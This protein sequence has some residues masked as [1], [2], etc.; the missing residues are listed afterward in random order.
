MEWYYVDGGQRAGPVAETEFDRLIGAGK[1]Q[2][3]TLV[4]R[5]GMAN[6][7]PLREIRPV[8]APATGTAY[9]PPVSSQTAP[10]VLPAP[11]ANEVVCA[12]CHG[13]F[14]RENTIQYGTSYVCAACKP[15]FIQ[16]LREGATTEV[17]MIYAGFWIR[18]GAK[19]IDGLVLLVLLIPFIIYV[20]VSFIKTGATASQPNFGQIAFQLL[21][22]FVFEALA[23][24]Y[25]TFFHG[26]YGATLGKLACGLKVVTPEGGKITYG[27]A[28]G[29]AMAEIISRIICSIGYII[30]AF[31]SQKRSL[32]DHIAST[33]VIR[34]R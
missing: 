14:P 30:A 2:P 21:G 8:A 25:R 31:D 24:A 13:V 4:W 33:R 19:L 32:H 17:G 34:V 28:F 23:V 29:R 6:W 20:V 27:R 15:A 1:I 5:D 26:K 11:A 16:K 12:H 9:T 10:G 7:Q 3:E 18:F 22:N